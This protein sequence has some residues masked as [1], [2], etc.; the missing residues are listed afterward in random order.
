[1]LR[2]IVHIHEDLCN[3][4]ELCVQACHEGA[5]QMVNGKAKLLHDRYCDGLGD[6]LP[7]CPTNAIEIIER[8]AVDYD[9]SAVVELLTSLGREIPEAMLENHNKHQAQSTSHAQPAAPSFGGC[10]G[11][12]AKKLANTTSDNS[13]THA[14]D[15]KQRPSELRQ[16]PIQIKLINPAADYLVN[17]HLL[18]AADC[19]AFAYG[20]FHK[21]FMK[22]KVTMIGCPKLD[23]NQ[24]YTEKF[25][26]MFS[27]GSIQSVT[28][29]R[30]EVPCC[31]GIVGAVQQALQQS[32][33][34]IPYH[35]AII[36]V[37]G[38]LRR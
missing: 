12:Q 28:V 38:Q 9:E 33:K 15:T 16:W 5:I 6:C 34:N 2:K 22:D 14:T 20:D 21:D 24:F 31:G 7:A 17:A 26:H 1:M 30:M 23:D 32:G 25:T 11:M 10:P 29:V 37:D 27:T 18:V 4:C 19:V 35:E 36:S 13:A 3:G 8:E